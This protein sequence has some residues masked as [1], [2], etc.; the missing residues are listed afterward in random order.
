MGRGQC[1]Y[2][3]T[4]PTCKC[5]PGTDPET[6]CAQC[7]Q[8][9][10][11]KLQWLTNTVEEFCSVECVEST[12]NGH[13]VCNPLAFKTPDDPLC[14]CDLNDYNMDTYNAT[15][16]CSECNRNWFPKDL[17]AKGACS[18]FCSDDVQD[19]LYSGCDGLIKTYSDTKEDITITTNN[20]Q[21]QEVDIVQ[22]IDAPEKARGYK[23]FKLPTRYL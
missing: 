1:V 11:P 4:E 12:C 8:N 21:G 23:L 14:L 7:A 9:K 20:L 2:Q 18:D 22:R 15:S 3:E 6:N 10:Y 16:R 19:S 13:G 5:N 17:N